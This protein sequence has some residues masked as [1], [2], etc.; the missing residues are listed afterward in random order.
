MAVAVG[1][2]TDSHGR[3]IRGKSPRTVTWVP[4]LPAEVSGKLRRCLLHFLTSWLRKASWRLPQLQP[5]EGD[6]HRHKWENQ[7]HSGEGQ[8]LWQITLL[9]HIPCV[10]VRISFCQPEN[11]SKTDIFGQKHIADTSEACSV[12]LYAHGGMTVPPWS[13]GTITR[14]GCVLFVLYC[15]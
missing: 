9:V 15:Q 2:F 8:L 13:A 10:V 14:L 1:A 5:L 12:G 11:C 6:G 7:P 3:Y 4:T